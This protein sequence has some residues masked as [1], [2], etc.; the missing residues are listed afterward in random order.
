MS[1]FIFMY[2]NGMH[3]RPQTMHTPLVR[4]ITI[5]CI[6]H[7]TNCMRLKKFTTIQFRCYVSKIKFEA[8]DFASVRANICVCVCVYAPVCMADQLLK[9]QCSHDLVYLFLFQILVSFMTAIGYFFTYF[10]V[11]E[12]SKCRRSLH[13]Y[14]LNNMKIKVICFI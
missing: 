8:Y 3:D 2:V 11:D 12:Y 6:V 1:V 13:Y 10:C 4:W 9:L 5:M 14:A 7:I